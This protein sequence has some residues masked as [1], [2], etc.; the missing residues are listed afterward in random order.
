M[1][2]T[3]SGAGAPAEAQRANV[4][5]TTRRHGWRLRTYLAGLVAL[6]V[7]AACAGAVFVHAQ[8][9][10]DAR[11]ASQRDAKFAAEASVKPIAEGITT[12]QTALRPFAT[13]PSI[14]VVL[15]DPSQCTLSFVKV[16]AY[17]TGHIDI[18]RPDGSVVCSSRAQHGGAGLPGYQGAAWLHGAAAAPVV[19][20]P[21]TDAATGNPSALVAYP[22]P[23][24]IA[25]AFLELRP[26]GPELASAFGGPRHLEFLV[27]TAD[28][29][30]VLA[31]STKPDRWVG[32][33]LNM[34]PFARAG[35]AVDRPDLEGKHRLYATATV[36]GLGWRVYAGDDRAAA[37]AA[38]ARLFRRDLAVI[39]GGLVVILVAAFV[40]QRRLTRPIRQLSTMV[41]AATARG[42]FGWVEISGPSEVV[43][44]A[45]DFHGLVVAAERELESASRLAAIVDSSGDAIIGKTLDGV[46]T[47]WNAGAAH[48]YGYTAEEVVGHSISLLVPP[49][50]TEELSEILA[51]V[52]TDE[53]VEPFETRRVR[54]DGTVFDASVSVSPIHD[55]AGAVIGASSVARDISGAKRSMEALQASEARKSAILESALDCVISIDHQGRIVEFNP[56]AEQAFGYA[57]EE[58]L[59]RTMA[60]L[61][62]PPSFRDRHAHGLAHYVATGEGPILGRRLELV[63]MRADGSEFPIEL[64]VTRVNLPGD[65]LFTGY[66]RDLTDQKRLQ[67][68]LVESEQRLQA[69]LDNSP[70]LICL[71]DAEGR[72]LFVNRQLAET[73]GVE[74]EAAKGRRAQDLWPPEAAQTYRDNDLEV[75]KTGAP[76]QYESVAAH[77]DGDRIYLTVKFP[78][79]DAAGTAYATASIATD[80]T[81]RKAA[82]AD[83][84]ALEARSNQS[85][86]LESL[87]QLAGGVAHDFNNLLA[88]I[89][90]Y[91]AFVAEAVTDNDAARADVEQIR[92]AAERAARLTHQLLIFGRRETVRPEILDLNA[93]VDDINT[94]LSRT[95]GEHVELVIRPADSLMAIRADRGQIEQVLLNLAVNA[96]DAM[97]AG[98]TLTIETRMTDLDEDFAQTHPE[99]GAGRYVDL[100]VSDTGV[101]MSPEVAGRV[102]EPF[103]TTKPKGQG[104]GLGLATVYG[105]VTG[106]GGGL[107]IYSE[108]GIGTT[109]RA[110]L[111]A[112]EEPVTSTT[113]P[114]RGGVT[115]GHGETVLVV[116][117]EPAMME[118]AA[119]ILRR[120]GYSVLEAATG[121][122]ALTL[123]ADHD[124]QLLLTDSVMPHMSGQELAGRMQ[125]VRPGLAVL[126]MSGYSE[127]VLGPQ[128][129]LDKNVAL[130]QKPFTAAALLEKVGEV[131]TSH[132][133]ATGAP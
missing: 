127:G 108:E 11:R 89:L 129:V 49:E 13:D 93:I 54:K 125:G 44:L 4:A 24:G 94:L 115:R 40:V 81:E 101:G 59:G 121:T 8:A 119:R 35:N 95:I 18:L 34:T 120:N 50:R 77:P 132:V 97:P 100:S 70:A 9:D 33:P 56:A 42:A 14:D 126:F 7:V 128:R 12:L 69:M 28:R 36:P 79:F 74:P 92:S 62:I 106:A 76:L 1:S 21:V 52:A 116:E 86:R 104:T 26:V 65:P 25:A 17:P 6:F 124:V 80:I 19:L 122:E 55:A 72:Y 22:F 109:I 51:R 71:T 57:R 98:G 58:V 110:Y 75:L 83:R 99:V 16:G 90:N 23:G 84:K 78:L 27:T 60:D 29:T 39:L 114:D 130:I 45:E 10:R 47:T 68:E 15:K 117:D 20:A 111:P 64:A 3:E 32:A 66:L 105:I 73:F 38:A 118:V 96:R 31:R 102:F 37:L 67:S 91:A 48:M 123:A 87:G 53:Q 63:A 46:I 43:G 30:M 133:A 61:I 5:T 103:F 112:A 131:L 82:E 41:R 2:A 85:Q 107:S 88:V 113:E